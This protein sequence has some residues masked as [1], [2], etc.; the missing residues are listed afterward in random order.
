MIFATEITEKY[1]NK[2]ERK[3]AK[4]TTRTQKKQKIISASFVSLCAFAFS[5]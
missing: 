4:G 5:F 1:E 2:D 3:D